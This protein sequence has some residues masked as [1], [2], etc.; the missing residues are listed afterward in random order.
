GACRKMPGIWE[1]GTPRAKKFPGFGVYVVLLPKND[2]DLGFRSRAR[3]SVTEIWGEAPNNRH[4]LAEGIFEPQ[5]TDTF[6][7][8][9]S[10][11]PK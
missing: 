9:A 7:Q 2:G 6:W 3:H 11:A 10:P 8:T 1:L 4:F 5:T